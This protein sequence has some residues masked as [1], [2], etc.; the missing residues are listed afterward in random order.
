MHAPKQNYTMNDI[1]PY[2]FDKSIPMTPFPPHFVTPKFDKYKGKGDPMAH[3][4][5]FFIACIEVAGEKT[6]LM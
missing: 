5:E 1:Y 3:I 4:I 6:Y 2:P